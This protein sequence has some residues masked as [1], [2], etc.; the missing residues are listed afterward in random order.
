[1]TGG[2]SI[3]FPTIPEQPFE[4]LDKELAA[5][6][7]IPPD[8][9]R[10]ATVSDWF[11]PAAALTKPDSKRLWEHIRED[12]LDSLRSVVFRNMPKPRAR[13]VENAS[14]GTII[15]T[16]EGMYTGLARWASG[17]AV[18]K[19]P[20]LLYI[21]SPGETTASIRAFV[22]PYPAVRD[23]TVR[24]AVFPRGIGAGLWN[25]SERRRFERC[26]MLLGRTLDS[27]RLYDILSVVDYVLTS[28]EHGAVTIAGKGTQGIIGA[29]AALFDDRIGRVI[30][31]SPP[32]RHE[33]GPIF[34][35]VLRV[36]DIPQAL[37]MLAPRELTVLTGEYDNFLYTRNV[38]DMLDA[39]DRFYRAQ[40]ISHVLNFRDDD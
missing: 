30:L 8:D 28:G 34:L 40:T 7:D 26:S 18:E 23:S 25:E 33:Q 17:Y 1:M 11:I 32:V 24:Y 20:I 12:K 31:H 15:E 36:T 9:A 5:F 2:L 19:P 39:H 27:M 14:D 13:I 10:N 21:A 38:F 29:Y 4:R 6:P 3:V 37:A 16:E 35:N 22:S